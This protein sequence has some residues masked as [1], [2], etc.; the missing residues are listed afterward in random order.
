MAEG[1]RNVL[2]FTPKQCSMGAWT[3]TFFVFLVIFVTIRLYLILGGALI[4]YPL[5]R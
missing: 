2:L 1:T 5:T 4:V 3:T